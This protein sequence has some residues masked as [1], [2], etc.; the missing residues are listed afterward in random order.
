MI[1]IKT[2]IQDMPRGCD[3]C[4][5]YGTRPHPYKGWTDICELMS[6]CM[7][8][9][10]PEEWVFDGNKRPAACPLVEFDESAIIQREDDEDESV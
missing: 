8:D 10:Q 5:W 7:D 2:D 1:A 9:D 4:R 3:Y 6:Q